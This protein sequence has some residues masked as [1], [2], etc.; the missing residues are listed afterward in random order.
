MGMRKPG[1]RR[2]V[3]QGSGRGFGMYKSQNFCIGVC[4]KCRFHLFR[5]NG[6]SPGIFYND[7]F[8]ATTYY[9]FLHPAAEDTIATDDNLVT[10]FNQIDKTAFHAGGARCRD[11]D[12]DFIFCLKGITQQF[13]QI[14]HHPDKKWIKMTNGRARNGFQNARVDIRGAGSH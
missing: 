14:V 11:R 6:S 12:G 9:V 2:G 8:A 1:Q 5:I 3:R 13:F 7:G 10:G 4:L